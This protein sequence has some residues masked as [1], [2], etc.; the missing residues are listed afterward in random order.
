[1]HVVVHRAVSQERQ[2]RQQEKQQWQQELQQ[3]QQRQQQ[4]EARIAALEAAHT[5]GGGVAQAAEQEWEPNP[6]TL[7]C[8]ATLQG[9]TDGVRALA[10]GRGKLFSGSFDST[11]R[12]WDVATHAHVTT[13]QGHTRSVMA[14]AV[15]G[16]KL[17]SGSD[18]D[19]VR[20]WAN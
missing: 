15:G 10:V 16:G 9:H 18:D 17:F 19:D 14:L 2:Q 1:M 6:A 3:W 5:A 13:L 20:V 8:T 4:L 11:M 7:H 12:V